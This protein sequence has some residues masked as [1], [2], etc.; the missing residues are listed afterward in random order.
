M[1][2]LDL[3]MAATALRPAEKP[4]VDSGGIDL[5]KD[6]TYRAFLLHALWKLLDLDFERVKIEYSLTCDPTKERCILVELEDTPEPWLEP[7]AVVYEIGGLGMAGYITIRPK[8]AGELATAAKQDVL[9]AMGEW[10]VR[11]N[12][13]PSGYPYRVCARSEGAALSLKVVAGK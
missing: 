12:G 11:Q 9:R 3:K 10:W 13:L 1:K 8:Q 4:R 6:A 2:S 7:T 5:A